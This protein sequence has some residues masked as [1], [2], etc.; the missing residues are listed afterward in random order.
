MWNSFFVNLLRSRI[1]IWLAKEM[2]FWHRL[3]WNVCSDVQF[4]LSLITRAIKDKLNFR[5]G[6]FI[7]VGHIVLENMLKCIRVLYYLCP[8]A[9]HSLWYFLPN[10]DQEPFKVAVCRISQVSFLWNLLEKEIKV[11]VTNLRDLTTVNLCF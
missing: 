10:S 3:H 8:V 6:N 4:G 5:G 2:I 9:F 11:I 1:E 7:R